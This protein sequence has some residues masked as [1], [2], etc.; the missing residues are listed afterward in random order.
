MFID[1]WYGNTREEIADV[2]CF[3]YPNVGVYR[4]NVYD[5]D[6]KP[7]GDY[8]ESDSCK[9]DDEFPGIFGD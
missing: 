7:I 9:I 4:G 2:D 3:F 5:K 1:F 8:E 6:G